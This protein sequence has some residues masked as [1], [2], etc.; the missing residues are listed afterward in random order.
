MKLCEPLGAGQK[1][2]LAGTSNSDKFQV[3]FGVPPRGISLI[4]SPTQGVVKRSGSSSGGLDGHDSAE[5]WLLLA[6]FRPISDK[7]GAFD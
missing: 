4:K 7:C 1:H 3:D 6:R 5:L 2:I